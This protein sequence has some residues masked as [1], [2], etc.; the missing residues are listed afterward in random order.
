MEET[1]PA[2]AQA[3]A[4]LT[5]VSAQP[6]EAVGRLRL[7]VP[8]VAVLFIIDPLLATFRTRHPRVEVELV[9]EDRFVDIVAEGYDARIRLWSSE[10]RRSVDCCR[11]FVADSGTFPGPGRTGC[12]IAGGHAA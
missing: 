8:R 2:L 3:A 9:I 11:F 10:R 4:T 6:G 12:K 5:E 7:S 1:G